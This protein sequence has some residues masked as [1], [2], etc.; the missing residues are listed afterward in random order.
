MG[1]IVTSENG[2]L[3]SE[4]QLRDVQNELT[5]AQAE[6]AAQQAR[7]ET[8]RSAPPEALADVVGNQA[9][10]SYDAKLTEL[11]QQLADA[12][13]VYASTSSK[14]T[15]IQA[16]VAEVQAALMRERANVIESIKNDFNQALGRE[17]LLLADYA[18]V[19]NQVTKDSQKSV[20]YSVLKREVDTNRQLYDGMLHQ[21]EEASI[22]SA[23]RS[24]NARI[25]DV[26][27]VPDRPAKPQPLFNGAIGWLGGV[28]LGCAGLVIRERNDR[29]IQTLGDINTHLGVSAL[30]SIP[31]CRDANFRK[32]RRYHVRITWS[33]NGQ[34]KI[35]AHR[36]RSLDPPPSQTF[37]AAKNSQPHSLFAESVRA[38]LASILLVGEQDDQ[39][40]VIVLT[41]AHP[42]EGKSTVT[43]NLGVE[44]AKTGKNILL[45]DA[46]TRK[47]DLH[48]L[49]G[50][51]NGSGL[52]DL[53]RD[54][55]SSGGGS[56]ES[57]AQLTQFPR[58]SIL[59]AGIATETDINLLYSPR[60]IKLIEAARQLYDMVL[61]DTPPVLSTCDARVAGRVAD[62]LVLVVRSC[63][64]SRD[65]LKSLCHR[66]S[67]DGTQILGTILNG[68]DP[69]N[70]RN[71]VPHYKA[72]GNAQS[73]EERSEYRNGCQ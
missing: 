27:D 36:C 52:A 43:C 48:R 40:R 37:E 7:Y 24:N 41:S 55:N 47:P 50:L 23:M 12:S 21:V 14:V 20:R 28:I 25:L 58:L 61:I 17:R 72:A 59:A 31:T 42:G 32:S 15:R 9:L 53:L 22:A 38:T 26:A 30:G 62:A 56:L 35:V 33:N 1:L 11:R 5:K 2:P 69:S 65:V 16:Q 44:L 10:R 54:Q 6:R 73:Y 51:P 68:W 57:I 71:N 66:I 63:R 64:T 29:T 34:R 67:D 45:V 4:E 49:F 13:A 18:T 39:P 60:F 3:L 70:N 19:S 46:D 8:A